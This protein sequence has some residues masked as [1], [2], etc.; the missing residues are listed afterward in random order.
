MVITQDMSRVREGCTLKRRLS[1]RR[2]IKGG[3]GRAASM[4][5][6]PHKVNKLTAS[7]SSDEEGSTRTPCS[8]RAE[9]G[10]NAELTGAQL[11]GASG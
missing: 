6:L 9:R 5:Q 11:F 2:S 4:A 3:A 10:G 7:P 1:V 8:P